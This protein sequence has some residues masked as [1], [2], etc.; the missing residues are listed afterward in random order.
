MSAE[1]T[2]SQS[3]W[4]VLH[5]SNRVIGI[6]L[7]CAAIGAALSVVPLVR[8]DGYL[9]T[10]SI[11]GSMLSFASVPLVLL[12]RGVQRKFASRRANKR[13]N[14]GLCARC[15]YDL[16]CKPVAPDMQCSECGWVYDEFERTRKQDYDE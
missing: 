3:A 1:P 10:L 8:P 2:P 15:G 13:V 12:V 4:P 7:L 6:W 9:V 16:R 11:A 5:L 14:D